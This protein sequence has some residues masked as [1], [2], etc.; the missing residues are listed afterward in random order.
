MPTRN[1]LTFDRRIRKTVQRKIRRTLADRVDCSKVGS[2]QLEW[3]G[4]S[5]EFLGFVFPDPF[6]VEGVALPLT[7]FI[8]NTKRSDPPRQPLW[9]TSQLPMGDL[10][11][12]VE[13]VWMRGVIV[14]GDETRENRSE[15]MV[16]CDRLDAILF[17]MLETMENGLPVFFL[18]LERDLGDPA[19]KSKF[20]CKVIFHHAHHHDS[21]CRFIHWGRCREIWHDPVAE[22]RICDLLFQECRHAIYHGRC[23][24]VIPIPP[25]LNNQLAFPIVRDKYFSKRHGVSVDEETELR[26]DREPNVIRTHYEAPMIIV[27]L[28]DGVHKPV[29]SGCDVPHGITI[30]RE[31]RV[32]EFATE[33]TFLG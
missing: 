9:T 16:P 13:I 33:L 29:L 15:K 2:G 11:P 3:I 32:Q 30:G 7:A 22:G 31:G 18:S 14:G 5:K 1:I 10:V 25:R 27:C 20:V 21:A 24:H 19:S 17:E 12:K 6:F 26:Y 4:G 8:E 23:V 28:D